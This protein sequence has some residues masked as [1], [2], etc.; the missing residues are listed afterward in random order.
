MAKAMLGVRAVNP[1]IRQRD[2]IM[3]KKFLKLYPKEEF[4]LTAYKKLKKASKRKV[5]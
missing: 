2:P 4:T 3:A 1:V 5:R